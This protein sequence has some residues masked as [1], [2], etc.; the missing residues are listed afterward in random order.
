VD[1]MGKQ[2]E[3]NDLM[4]SQCSKGYRVRRIATETLNVTVAS[5]T[6][7]LGLFV[8]PCACKVTKVSINAV[9]Y[10]NYDSATLD[11]A[12]AVIGGSDLALITQ[13]DIDNKTAETEIEATL[14]TANLNLIEGQEV[15]ATITIDANQVAAGSAVT[16]QVEYMPTE[17]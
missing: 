12:K 15:Y 4:I 16:V 2:V 13:L 14:T 11:V 10:P 5:T 8:A 9:T 6:Y 1:D 3:A 7:K 17:S